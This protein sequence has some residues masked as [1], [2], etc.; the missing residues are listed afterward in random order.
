MYVY[1]LGMTLYFAAE[2]AL[3]E[4]KVPIFYERSFDFFLRF[5]LQGV[6]ANVNIYCCCR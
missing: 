3:N 5:S 1:S 2:Y 6:D 4:A